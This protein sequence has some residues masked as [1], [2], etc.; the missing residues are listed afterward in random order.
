MAHGGNPYC[1]IGLNVCP[2][3]SICL[4]QRGKGTDRQ[5]L[6]WRWISHLG[7]KRIYPLLGHSLA[8]IPGSNNMFIVYQYKMFIWFDNLYSKSNISTAYIKF[9]WQILKENIK[10]TQQL[11][12]TKSLKQ[13]DKL[14]YIATCL[15][16]YWLLG[17]QN[18][19]K[20]TESDMECTDL[21]K[22]KGNIVQPNTRLPTSH[23]KPIA[24]N[25]AQA[26]CVAIIWYGWIRVSWQ[27]QHIASTSRC[28]RQ[29]MAELEITY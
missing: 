27:G 15:D 1:Y 22:W 12:V 8:G 18:A 24:K 16:I 25:S 14:S 5:Q 21:L 23:D 7:P 19:R 26:S 17:G 10:L 4:H 13:A 3:T 6:R 9:K 11:Q 29:N 2:S 20:M 28:R